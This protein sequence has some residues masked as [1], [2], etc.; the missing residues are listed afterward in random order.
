MT[1]AL[2][3]LLVVLL[4]WLALTEL[5]AG[6]DGHNSLPFLIALTPL[7]WIGFVIL[8]VL[9]CLEH[10]WSY[11]TCAAIGLVASLLRKTS[12]YMTY[13]KSPNTGAAIAKHYQEKAA[14]EERA[15]QGAEPEPKKKHAGEFHAMTLNCR[16]GH[17]DAGEIVKLVKAHDVAVLALQEC[18]DELIKRLDAAGLNDLLPYHELG[19]PTAE[20][21]GGFNGIWLRVEPAQSTPTGCPIPAADVPTVTLPLSSTR[22]IT[23]ASAHPKSPQRGCKEWS[24]G[25]IGLRA[26][27]QSKVDQDG[28]QR[29]AVVMGDLN[30][31]L[32]HPSFRKLLAG[33]FHDA[34]VDESAAQHP[35]WPSWLHWP[36]LVLDHILFT[37]DLKASQVRSVVVKGTDH[38]ALL[39]TLTITGR[40]ER[41]DPAAR[42][43]WNVVLPPIKR[44]EPVRGAKTKAKPATAKAKD[45]HSKQS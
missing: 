43:E 13:L 7:L 42:E 2:W 28:H 38:L 14:A 40:H 34:A 10:D 27:V 19:E 37:D 8:V 26:L 21:N 36:R 11:V 5:P 12:Y 4:V 15:K 17:A 41:F 31:A 3:V 29:V 9:G 20:D 25:I 32:P 23:F 16:Y 44:Q 24:Q 33:G 1:I 22:D 39:A 35:T 6:W 18:S 45:L 30:S